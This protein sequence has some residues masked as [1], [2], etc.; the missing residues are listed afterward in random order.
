[1]ATVKD[2]YTQ[3][4]ANLS[5]MQT[6]LNAHRPAGDVEILGTTLWHHELAAFYRAY[7]VDSLPAD[8]LFAVLA[9][10]MGAPRFHEGLQIIDSHPAQ[11][12]QF[13]NEN[14]TE[15]VYTVLYITNARSLRGPQRLRALVI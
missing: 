4:G 5:K 11:F 15:S 13:T 9:S 3:E 10:L 2:L 7:Y 8:G 12:G 1:M 14:M 6:T